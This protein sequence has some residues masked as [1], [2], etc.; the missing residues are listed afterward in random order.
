MAPARSPVGGKRER[1][2]RLDL[3]DAA[4]SALAG[5]GIE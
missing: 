3:D 2:Q 4:G 5:R 1:A